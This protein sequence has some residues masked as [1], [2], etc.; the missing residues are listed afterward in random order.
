[1][2]G[3]GAPI[4]C[5]VGEDEKVLEVNGSGI[6]DTVNELNTTKLCA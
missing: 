3:R 2:G 4:Y 6:S 5:S 1:M